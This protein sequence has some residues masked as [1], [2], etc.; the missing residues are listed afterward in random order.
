MPHTIL[1]VDDDPGILGIGAVMLEECGCVVLT[2]GSGGAALAKLKQTPEIS[3]LLTDVQMPGMDGYELAHRA[4]AIRPGLEV[5]VTSG[6]DRTGGGF[7]FLPNPF[8]MTEL[9]SVFGV[10]CSGL[11]QA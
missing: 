8:S 6:T 1:L 2:A 5:I 4:T 9:Q 11:A 10:T 7:V 3:H